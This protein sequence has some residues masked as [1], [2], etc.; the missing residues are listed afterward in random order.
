MKLV[1]DSA[2]TTSRRGH[3]EHPMVHTDDAIRLVEDTLDEDW[4]LGYRGG[5]W[6]GTFYRFS[7]SERGSR[8]CKK[9]L[10]FINAYSIKMAKRGPLQESDHNFPVGSPIKT[11]YS[12]VGFSRLSF[13]IWHASGGFFWHLPWHWDLVEHLERGPGGWSLWRGTWTT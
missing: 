11:K 4:C 13:L 8:P 6:S 10:C 2:N 3:H 12:M 9:E 7:H 5:D 1:K